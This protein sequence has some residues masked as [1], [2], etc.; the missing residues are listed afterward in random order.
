MSYWLNRSSSFNSDFYHF[1]ND[2]SNFSWSTT[3]ALLARRPHVSNNAPI[4]LEPLKTTTRLFMAVL[5]RQISNFLA[6]KTPKTNIF[7]VT[8]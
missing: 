3:L 1:E 7:F 2:K 8:N 4:K 5:S 6:A